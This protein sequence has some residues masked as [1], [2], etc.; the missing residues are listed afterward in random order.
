MNQKLVFL[1]K[2][3]HFILAS[4]STALYNLLLSCSV[5]EIQW[6]MDT[7]KKC[8]KYI[9]YI[10]SVVLITL[11]LQLLLTMTRSQI[12]VSIL[13]NFMIKLAEQ[14]LWGRAS[15]PLSNLIK[16]N[17][18]DMVF[19]GHLTGCKY[20]K[21]SAALNPKVQVRLHIFIGSLKKKYE[22]VKF[23]TILIIQVQK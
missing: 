21:Q 16:T 19:E 8:K 2:S 1:I 23:L 17:L 10:C 11:S 7:R 14:T 13:L 5:S 6:K 15:I 9:D 18:K 12:S 3:R 20:I 4:P 22:D